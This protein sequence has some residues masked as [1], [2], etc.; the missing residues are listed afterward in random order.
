MSGCFA[1]VEWSSEEHACCVVDEHGRIVEGRRYRHDE[2]GISALRRRLIDL[3]V[4]LVGVERPDGLLIDRL[5]DAGPSVLAI[6]PTL[7]RSRPCALG[8]VRPVALA[9]AS[10]AL[11]PSSLAPIATVI[12]SWSRT[13]IRPRRC[14]R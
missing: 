2:R 9:T 10:T 1:G 13:P 6:R 11:C 14:A 7:I 3:E 5:L 8:S 12:G 4:E